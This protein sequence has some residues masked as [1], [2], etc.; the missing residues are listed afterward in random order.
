MSVQSSLVRYSIDAQAN[1]FTVQAFASGIASVVAHSPKFAI[2]SFF[3]EAAFTPEPIGD[4][5]LELTIKLS[6]LDLMDDV[7]STE[8][9]EIERVMF[10]KVLETNR[11]ATVRFKSTQV[12]GIK[13]NE[14]MFRLN[15][16]GEL[17]LHG[18]TR[19]M[20]IESQV[21]KGEDTMKAQGS[22]SML[23]S[24]YGLKIA[25]LAGGS[26]KLKDELKCAYFV[27]GRREN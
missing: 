25:S 22:F 18:I 6:S 17:R 3:G 14:N 1:L 10:D 15:V 20:H 2:R 4:S 7:R 26:L 12:T 16:M 11:C 13:L 21:M 9:R 23:Q 5:S 8:R 27:A 19:G 24:D